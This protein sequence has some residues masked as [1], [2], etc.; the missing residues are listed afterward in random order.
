MG[1][2]YAVSK[3]RITAEYVTKG[4]NDGFLLKS[5]GQ[6]LVCEVSDASYSFASNL[7]SHLIDLNCSEIEAYM[8]THY[9]K[10]HTAS[11]NKLT[12]NCIVRSFILPL[13]ITETDAQ[14]YGE[15]CA[16][17]GEKGIQIILTDRHRGDTVYFNRAEVEIYPFTLL[18]RSDHP[19]IALRLS[20]DDSEIMYLGG[21]FNEGD[22]SISIHAENADI[23]IFGGHSPVYK[24]V[25]DPQ[26]AEAKTVYVSEYAAE[27]LGKLSPDITEE[28]YGENSLTAEV[29]IRLD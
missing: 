2:D 25:F 21:S 7:T 4:K 14:V 28:L 19:V 6:V 24:K 12:D 20:C 13:P 22:E 23:L 11:L 9:H 10:K 1:I 29:P 8:L 26:I 17:A 3:H 5:D 15:L 16:I 27:S 18:S